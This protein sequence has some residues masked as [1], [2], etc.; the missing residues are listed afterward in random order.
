MRFRE[1]RGGDFNAKARRREERKGSTFFRTRMRPL[2][3]VF[4]DFVDVVSSR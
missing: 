3:R 2:L 4:V 1:E